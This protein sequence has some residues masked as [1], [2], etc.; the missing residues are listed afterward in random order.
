VDSMQLA[1]QERA[2]FAAFLATLSARIGVL[3]S[4]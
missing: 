1:R 3:G 4:S 2:E